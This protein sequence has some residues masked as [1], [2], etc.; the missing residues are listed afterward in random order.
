[1]RARPVEAQAAR[2]RRERSIELS[3]REEAVLRAYASGKTVDAV[4]RE[5]DLQVSTV[6]VYLNRARDKYEQAGREA[7]TRVDLYKRAVEDGLVPAPNSPTGSTSLTDRSA[8]DTV[9]PATWLPSASIRAVYRYVSARLGPVAQWISAEDVTQEVLLTYVSYRATQGEIDGGTER[10]LL[11]AIAKK[12]IA[13]THRRQLRES[14]DEVRVSIIPEELVARTP[15][16]QDPELA[17]DLSEDMARM[18]DRLSSA[19]R[20]VLLLRIASGLSAAE[21]AEV[22]GIS[23][24]SVRVLHHR[25]LHRL[26]ALVDAANG[27][28]TG[29]IP[30]LKPGSEPSAER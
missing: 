2:P 27:P 16:T 15:R 28:A 19:H 18:L 26:R 29:Q 12:K 10:K 5:L 7:E 11:F 8:I 13:D 3:P 9:D 25:A 14:Q 1:M 17:E 23:P 6:R 30:R 22:M 24:G 20:D 21:T 4:A